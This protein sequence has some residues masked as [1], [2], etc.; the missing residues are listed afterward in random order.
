M[1]Q[2]A[3]HDQ[4][5][6]AEDV[7][8]DRVR[9]FMVVDAPAAAPLRDVTMRSVSV[10]G[11]AKTLDLENVEGLQLDKVIVGGQQID[12]MLTWRTAQRG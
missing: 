12:G 1:Q 4:E 6:E 5:T 10:G 2:I 9:R 3:G 11:A 7:R 8:A